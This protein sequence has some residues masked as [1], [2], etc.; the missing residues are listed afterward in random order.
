MGEDH[1]AAWESRLRQ[2]VAALGFGQGDLPA[3]EE[4]R[5]QALI[6]YVDLLQQWGAAYNLSAVKTPS[7]IVTLHLL[8]CLAV[9][10]PLRRHL[11]PIGASGPVDLLDVGSGAGLPGIILALA[12]PD[13]R[14]TSVDAVAK[15]AAFMR[16]AG[17]RL[18]LK[19]FQALHARVEDLTGRWAVITSRAF[20]SLGDFVRLTRPLLEPGGVWM[21]MKGRPDPAELDA[22]GPG[23]DHR[24]EALAVPGLDARRCLVWLRPKE[25]APAAALQ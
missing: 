13:L 24:V 1:S 6:R 18:G 23:F 7:D 11:G 3:L 5:I 9:V 10:G 8:D 19:N 20:S 16:Q 17:A 25:A 12:L 14:V 22:L 21:A 4:D 2:G 15:K